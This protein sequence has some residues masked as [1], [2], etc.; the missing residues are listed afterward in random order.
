MGDVNVSDY[1][2]FLCEGQGYASFIHKVSL[3]LDE[4][5]GVSFP[6]IEL[7][8]SSDG[9]LNLKER[10]VVQFIAIRLGIDT[11]TLGEMIQVD[12][13]AMQPSASFFF[14]DEFKTPS[15]IKLPVKPVNFCMTCFINSLLSKKVPIFDACM[16]SPWATHCV[17]HQQPLFP[18]TLLEMLSVGEPNFGRYDDGSQLRHWC[19]RIEL[20]R[21]VLL[22]RTRSRDFT[23]GA[24]T[25][26]AVIA[27]NQLFYDEDQGKLGAAVLGLSDPLES[28]RQKFHTVFYLLS[29]RHQS[30]SIGRNMT[31]HLARGG[32]FPTADSFNSS[33]LEVLTADQKHRCIEFL[34]HFIANPEVLY[35][36]LISAEIRSAKLDYIRQ[37]N[38][39]NPDTMDEPLVCLAWILRQHFDRDFRS[40]I[41]RL[42]PK[43]ATTW[44]EIYDSVAI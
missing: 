29:R 27:I 5:Q 31:H 28:I 6:D 30:W 23:L 11:D 18:I 37:T 25:S 19:N 17:F 41:E 15:S 4:Q 39:K 35:P 38:T 21:I 43:Y 20:A 8:L 1:S 36:Y 14:A 33:L 32:W 3:W 26:K 22:E 42:F 13:D 16:Q 34:A 44:S 40:N 12:L 2:Q 7:Q 10:S 9:V 24:P